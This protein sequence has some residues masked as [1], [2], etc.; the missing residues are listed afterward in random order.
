M[1]TIKLD[2]EQVMVGAMFVYSAPGCYE[3]ALYGCDKIIET[4]RENNSVYVIKNVGDGKKAGTIL[5]R[6]YRDGPDKFMKT[7]KKLI[8]EQTGEVMVFLSIAFAPLSDPDIRKQIMEAQPYEKDSDELKLITE[9]IKYCEG[10]FDE[11]C[12]RT[13]EK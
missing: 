2:T 1:T 12:M 5:Y 8:K 3:A 7:F 9:S 4:A 6:A 10:K 13:V 11:M